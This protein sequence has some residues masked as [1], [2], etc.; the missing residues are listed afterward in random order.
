MA[1]LTAVRTR[2]ELARQELAPSHQP[3]QRLLDDRRDQAPARGQVGGQEGR[4]GPCPPADERPERFGGGLEECLRKTGRERHAERVAVAARV[5][6]RDPA[7]GAADTHGRCPALALKLL[8]PPRLHAPDRQLLRRE[9]PQARQEVVG[10]VGV[11]RPP[12]LL[13]ALELELQLDH[14]LR[15][16][17][18][19]ELLRAEQLGQELAVQG[20]G[21]RAALGERS[22]SLVDELADVVEEQ[23]G[24]ER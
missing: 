7:F 3:V 20:Q 16:E 5:L 9:V 1:V 17:Q 18:L 12:L 15:V 22:V 24:G 23:R 2:T 10:L 4:V 14:R 19:A 21:L 13:E 11:S 6:G 8:D